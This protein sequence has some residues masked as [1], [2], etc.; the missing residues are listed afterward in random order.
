MP[1]HGIQEE[2]VSGGTH[3][4]TLIELLVTVAIITLLS[5]IV[6]T[7]VQEARRRGE[8]A[9]ASIDMHT[10]V[11]AIELYY[12]D[13]GDWPPV[14]GVLSIDTTSTGNWQ[15]L[16]NEL[17]PTYIRKDIVPAFQSIGS[18]GSVNQGYIYLK[19]TPTTPIPVS[20]YSNSGQFIVCLLVYKGYWIDVRWPS[21]NTYTTRDGGIDPSG[22]EAFGGVYTLNNV[23]LPACNP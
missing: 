9:K 10:L 22:L 14:N 5:S 7:S 20:M 17:K 13:K 8:N 3:G 2:G 18:G 19:G 12:Q 1:K 11:N 23:N 16:M 4:F 15:G 21:G 6:L